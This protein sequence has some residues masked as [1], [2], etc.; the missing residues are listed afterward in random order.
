MGVGSLS[1]SRIQ[2]AINEIAEAKKVAAQLTAIVDDAR[3]IVAD[4]IDN[5]GGLLPHSAYY[6]QG[7]RAN[8]NRWSD[9]NKRAMFALETDVEWMLKLPES[10]ES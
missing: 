10:Q 3:T 1:E 8:L 9:A 7:V 5:S 4:M 6:L 2:Q